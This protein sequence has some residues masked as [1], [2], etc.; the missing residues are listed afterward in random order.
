MS[1]RIYNYVYIII[2]IIHWERVPKK[3][4]LSTAEKQKKGRVQRLEP[5]MFL[6]AKAVNYIIKLPYVYIVLLKCTP[7]FNI[8]I[9]I[10]HKI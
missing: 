7:N 2:C 9:I 1:A 4:I 5:S 10:T 8:T 6:N 3:A